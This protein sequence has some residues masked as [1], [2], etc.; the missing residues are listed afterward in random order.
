MTKKAL[1]IKTSM[2]LNLDFANNNNIL[3]CSFF[4]FIIIELY[5]LI[6]GVIVQISNPIA[7]HV[8]PVGISSNMSSNCR[9]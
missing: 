5:C 8:I 9:G 6:P 1:E 2:L 7:E 3:S 4:F